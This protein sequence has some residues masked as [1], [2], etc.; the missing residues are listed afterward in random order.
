MGEWQSWKVEVTD[1]P[2]SEHLDAEE[3]EAAVDYATAHTGGN[4]ENLAKL[5]VSFKVGGW[6]RLPLAGGSQR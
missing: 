4:S 3:E 2:P 5:R 6:S 1:E